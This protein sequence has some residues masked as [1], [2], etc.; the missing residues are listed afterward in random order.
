MLMI[1]TFQ[2]ERKLAKTCPMRAAPSDTPP[3]VWG[4]QE[5]EAASKNVFEV[6]DGLPRH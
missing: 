2:E 6:L 3:V 5:I 4:E 1:D